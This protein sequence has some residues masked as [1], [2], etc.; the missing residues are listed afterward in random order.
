AEPSGLVRQPA[1]LHEPGSDAVG[2]PQWARYVSPGSASRPRADAGEEAPGGAAGRPR[3]TAS[4]GG[5]GLSAVSR[6]EAALPEPSRSAGEVQLQ[7][8]EAR[9][10][11]L[12]G[13]LEAGA[14]RGENEA[15]EGQVLQMQ[16]DLFA[17][18]DRIRDRK[19]RFG[20]RAEALS[21]ALEAEQAVAL[22][23]ER[24]LVCTEDLMRFHEEQRRLMSGHWR[25]Q[26]ELKDERIRALN[27]Q[28]TEYTI[29]WQHL[30]AQRQTDA[31]LSHELQCLQ[32]RHRALAR[33]AAAC[34]ASREGLAAR[35]P[36]ARAAEA[37]LLREEAAAEEAA[38]CSRAAG[39]RAEAR[40]TSAGGR[41]RRAAGPAGPSGLV[42]GP[43]AAATGGA[44]LRAPVHLARRAGRA[45]EAAEEDHRPAGPH[46]QRAAPRA[47]GAC[48]ADRAPRGDEG[49]APRGRVVA[50]RGRAPPR[51]VAAAGPG[52]GPGEA[53]PAEG[54]GGAGAALPWPRARRP[55]A[56][57]RRGLRRRP[58]G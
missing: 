49:Q 47:V 32:D 19:G 2:L 14:L 7:A 38:A 41:G 39:S 40:E 45:G 52:P 53:G 56:G 29:D 1:L 9:R 15:L 35:L 42:G 3:P 12:Q 58:A 31:S 26:C 34:Q 55:A 8:L 20:E 50:A 22:E 57:A 11:E 30:G 5:G 36:E 6:A 21:R 48:E 54:A 4:G 27:L 24:R 10:A 25:A 28:L 46:Q 13:R 43:A 37:E 51:G 18:Q 16:Q 17:L 44:G 33:E 23:A